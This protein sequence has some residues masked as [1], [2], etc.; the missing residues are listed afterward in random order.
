MPQRLKAYT[1]LSPVKTLICAV[2]VLFRLMQVI[3]AERLIP[4]LKKE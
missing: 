4:K 2:H 3:V 1:S